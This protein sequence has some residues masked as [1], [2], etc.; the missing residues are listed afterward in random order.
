MCISYLSYFFEIHC[1]LKYKNSTIITFS[2]PL[3]LSHPLSPSLSL[4]ATHFMLYVLYQV[5]RLFTS[6]PTVVA[7]SASLFPLLAAFMHCDGLQVNTHM[8]THT[9]IQ[10]IYN[11]HDVELC[12]YRYM[13]ENKKKRKNICRIGLYRIK[14]KKCCCG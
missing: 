4:Y 12:D 3:T 1:A 10:Y 5:P 7:A 9:H 11:I 14:T 6:D 8:H 2:S 13:M